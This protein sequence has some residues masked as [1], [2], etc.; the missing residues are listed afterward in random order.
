VAAAALVCLT[1]DAMAVWLLYR[2]RQIILSSHADLPW[3]R[4]IAQSTTRLRCAP[5]T[6]SHAGGIQ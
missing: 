4:E 1:V 5:E 2:D 3:R 6:R